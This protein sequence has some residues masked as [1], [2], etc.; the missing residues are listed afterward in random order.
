MGD[1]SVLGVVGKYGVPGRNES[2]VKLLELCMEQELVV[3]NTLFKKDI[4]KYT[5]CR[6]AGGRMIDR[7]LTD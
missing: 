6:V 4:N 7:A 2:G 1:I 5:W 3:G